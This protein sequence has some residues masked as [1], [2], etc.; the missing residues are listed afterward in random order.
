MKFLRSFGV[1]CRVYFMSS[2]KRELWYLIDIA[3]S[4]RSKLKGVTKVRKVGDLNATFE[5]YAK[6]KKRHNGEGA[7]EPVITPTLHACSI[8]DI[9]RYIFVKIKLR[10]FS[11]LPARVKEAK[12][13]LSRGTILASVATVSQT[14]AVNRARTSEP[15]AR[16]LNPTSTRRT[17]R[18]STLADR[19]CGSRLLERGD[20]PHSR[21]ALTRGEDDPEQFDFL[22]LSLRLMN[23]RSR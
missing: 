3:V 17:D 9:A 8:P 10:L 4:T 11:Y 14:R 19:R 15:V 22:T 13:L 23:L 16:R 21:H 20:H 6:E 12:A 2:R 18:A 5:S 1:L 7:T